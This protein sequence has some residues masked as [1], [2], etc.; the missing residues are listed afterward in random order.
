[1]AAGERMDDLERVETKSQRRDGIKPEEDLIQV[2]RDQ[3]V[4]VSCCEGS[5]KLLALMG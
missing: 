3:V 5:A 1:M 4:Y 2:V